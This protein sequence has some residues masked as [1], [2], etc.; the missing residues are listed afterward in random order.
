MTLVLAHAKQLEWAIFHSDDVA[1]LHLGV[2]C[3]AQ[4][5]W[6]NVIANLRAFPDLQKVLYADD[7][8]K[9]ADKH[10]I[11]ALMRSEYPGIEW[12]WY[13]ELKRGAGS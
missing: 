7:H 6:D 4:V 5:G 9:D 10:E 11:A 12:A 8:L 1:E 2:N 3:L 13:S